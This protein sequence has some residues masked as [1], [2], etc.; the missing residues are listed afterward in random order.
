[1]NSKNLFKNVCFS[2]LSSWKC[3]TNWR[4]TAPSRAKSKN[5]ACSSALVDTWT[6]HSQNTISAESSLT[7]ALP[8]EWLADSPKQKYRAHHPIGHCA[9]KILAAW[10]IPHWGCYSRDI[11]ELDSCFDDEVLVDLSGSEIEPIFLSVISTWKIG[12]Y[13]ESD[14]CI[15]AKRDSGTI[16]IR[17]NCTYLVLR[18]NPSCNIF[19]FI[20]HWR[21]TIRSVGCEPP[22]PWYRD[23]RGFHRC[24]N[25]QKTRNTFL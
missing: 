5:F 12:I 24:H 20:A 7:P 8:S 11:K 1:M 23:E 16:S 2:K 21:Y 10:P 13:P 19:K 22:G 3:Q 15:R 4:A 17:S 9:P 14:T 18:I 25:I 6:V